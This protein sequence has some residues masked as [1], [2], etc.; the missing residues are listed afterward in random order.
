[1]S[2]KISKSDEVMDQLRELL[3]SHMGKIIAECDPIRGEREGDIRESKF[4][5]Y[6]EWRCAFGGWCIKDRS[7]F[8]WVIEH[9]GRIGN[10]G[11]SWGAQIKVH[12][13]KETMDAGKMHIEKHVMK[14]I[15]N[16][17]LVDMS[18]QFRSAV[19]FCE[20]MEECPATAKSK[21]GGL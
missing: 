4:D 15:K 7:G 17:R 12:H 21:G 2:G 18:A 14:C 6:G 5:L 11:K 13:Y 10:D 20:F 3:E 9:D 8:K 1:M 16:F 19:E